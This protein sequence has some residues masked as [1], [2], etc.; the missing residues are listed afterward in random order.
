[1]KK[2]ILEVIKNGNRFETMHFIFY[3][4][5]TK[6]DALK[7]C[8]K[9]SSKYANSVKRNRIKRILR[10]L[11][12]KEFKNGDIVTVVKTFCNNL[13]KKELIEEWEKLLK[14]NLWYHF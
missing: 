5:D 10:N 3:I 4:K 6:S 8:F 9:I 12:K 7:T 2:E 14:Q 13:T 11:M 1:M